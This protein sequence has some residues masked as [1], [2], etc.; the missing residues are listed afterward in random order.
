MQ[1]MRADRGR[2]GVSAEGRPGWP[3]AQGGRGARG[4][5]RGGEKWEARD[6]EGQRQMIDVF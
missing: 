3:A 4:G 1:H 2:R 6:T 5:C